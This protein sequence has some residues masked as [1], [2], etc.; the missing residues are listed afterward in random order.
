MFTDQGHLIF[1]AC[2][3][4]VAHYH[5]QDWQWA[6]GFQLDGF[7]WWEAFITEALPQVFL[8][9]F[10]KWWLAGFTQRFASISANLV[11]GW[12]AG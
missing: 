6:A 1:K 3:S 5:A 8:L 12:A 11:G 2:I 9:S 7:A 4:Q 10:I